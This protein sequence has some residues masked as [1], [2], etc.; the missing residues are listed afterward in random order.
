MGDFI[1]ATSDTLLA[2]LSTRFT[3]QIE[4]IAVEALGHILSNSASARR[5][6]DDVLRIG[7]VE[8]G[9]I[10]RVVTQSTGEEGERPDLACYDGG[11]ERVLI[12]AKFW[13]GLTSN[14]PVAYLER[15]PKDEPS[16]LL[17]IAPATRFQSL[18]AELKRLVESALIPFG[19]TVSGNATHTASVG[20]D[21]ALMMTSWTALLDHMESRAINAGDGTAQNDIQQLRG[22][23]ARADEETLLPIRKEQLGLEFPRFMT[24]MNKLVDDA[25]RL[26]KSKHLLETRAKA[27]DEDGYGQNIRLL[28]LQKTDGDGA[29]RQRFCVNFRLWR[30]FR[31]TPLWITTKWYMNWS[32][33]SE[34]LNSQKSKQS[35]PIDFV[36]EARAI[37]IYLRMGVEYSAVLDDVV[38]QIKRLSD[39]LKEG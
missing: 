31:E 8:V 7:G 11:A 6:L 13:A 3:D 26:A 5:G 38:Q 27:H 36:D 29:W 34:K 24:H 17:F 16:A 21:R 12:E 14:Q 32:V 10:S 15:L 22:L 37:P 39:M 30:D 35:A 1:M 4:N 19:E 33:L 18:W 28:P 9:D 25:T 2:H 23:A 20:G